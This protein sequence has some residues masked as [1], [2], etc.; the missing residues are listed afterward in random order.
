MGK[1]AVGFGNNYRGIGDWGLGIGDWVDFG[2]ASLS[3]QSPVPKKVLSIQQ[4]RILS[5]AETSPRLN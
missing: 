4:S 1:L 5:I 3:S 2:K